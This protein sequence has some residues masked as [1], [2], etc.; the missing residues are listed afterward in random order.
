MTGN[1]IYH[2]INGVGFTPVN[3]D[4][5]TLSFGTEQADKW[6]HGIG[7]SSNVIM[8]QEGYIALNNHLDTVGVQQAIPYNITINSLNLPCIV[9]L[10]RGFSVNQHQAEVTVV[11]FRSKN[12]LI[13][14]IQNITW[15]S[16][17]HDGIITTADMV[18]IPYVV[19][20]ENQGELMLNNAIMMYVLSTQIADSVATTARLV[21]EVIGNS[22]PDVV[23]SVSPGTTIKIGGYIKYGLLIALELAKLVLL[24]IALRQ[25]SQQM[26]ELIYPKVRNYRAM[27]VDRLLR[28]GLGTQGVQYT[29]T[30]AGH[31]RALVIIPVPI[32]FKAKKW[33]EIFGDE[34]SRILNRGYPT[35]SDTVPTVMS[36]IDELCKIY[37]IE[38][39]LMGNT[40]HLEPKGYAQ[41]LPMVELQYNMNDQ[42]WIEQSYEADLS[43]VWNTKITTYTNDI[44]DKLLFDNPKGLRCEYRS[45][46]NNIAPHNE[47]TILKGFVENRINFAL[48]TIKKE[49]KVEKALKKTAKALDKFL[50]TNLMSRLKARDGVLAVSAS[51]F[52]VTKLIYQKGGRQVPNY[53]DIIGANA[54]YKAYHSIDEPKNQCFERYTNMPLAMNNEQFIGA[55]TNKF[56]NLE[57]KTVEFE[58]LE[59]TPET[60]TAVATYKVRNTKWGQNIITELI[61]AE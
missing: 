36:L 34:D 1:L 61:Y 6:K 5:F 16:L 55:V 10:S 57:G 31:F 58:S 19:V 35:S 52:G 13:A 49:T 2:F 26:M 39:I 25:L 50:G 56:V 54:I 23:V 43:G 8:P 45:R 12:N 42:E 32:D 3:K 33:F 22:I 15:E 7:F 21:A 44:M 20:K 4:D 30:L 59:Y 40:L 24:T 29:S 11:P 38:P 51:E 14:N 18:N 47:M 60:S 28:I 53:V 27:S 46:P 17:A 48:G 41:T 9:D 37:N